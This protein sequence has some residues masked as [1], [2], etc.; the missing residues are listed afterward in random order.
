MGSGKNTGLVESL[1]QNFGSSSMEPATQKHKLVIFFRSNLGSL[2]LLQ[3]ARPCLAWAI[4]CNGTA[5]SDF[6]AIRFLSG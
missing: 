4:K 1:L 5:Q 3:L 6:C 2:V